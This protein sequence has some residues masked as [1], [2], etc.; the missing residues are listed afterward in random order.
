MPTM[1]ALAAELGL[2]R[3]TVSSV[4]NGHGAKLGFSAATIKRVREY[5]RTRGYVPSRYAR[6]IRTQERVVGILH[7][8]KLYTHLGEAFNRLSEAL[9]P[10]AAA[11]EIMVASEERL[12]AC[13][14][15]LLARRVTDLVW[16][17]NNSA[18]EPYREECIAGYLDN[19]RTVICGYLFDSPL[20][21]ADLLKR[22]FCLVGVE[23]VRHIRRMARF[24]LRLGH[25]TIALPTMAVTPPNA[26]PSSEA[27]TGAGLDVV[28]VPIPFRA[29]A[30][31]EAMRTR[32][33]TAAYFHGDS[34]AC[35]AIRGLRAAGV[36]IP[37]D[38]TVVGFD[39]M[40]APYDP[41]LTT[42]EMPVRGM[43][44][45]VRA[46]VEGRGVGERHCFALKLREGRT[47]GPPRPLSG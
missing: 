30:L 25:R 46:I 23:R 16:L 1:A 24:L 41:D 3:M 44:A 37:D 28:P 35:L 14:R 7:M 33:V 12:E 10:T 18:Y 27:F 32:G 6:G 31:I 40:S 5:L 2:S 17:H 26:N 42:L 39:G 11:L 9:A 29:E 21:E 20:G 38:L 45:Q 13:V 36:R 15:E 47:H 34:A 4:L 19:T 8:G 43:V 22:G